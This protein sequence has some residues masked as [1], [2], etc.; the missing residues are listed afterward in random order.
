[1]DRNNFP[2]NDT[3]GCEFGHATDGRERVDAPE[4]TEYHLGFSTDPRL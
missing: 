1:M 2:A 4:S 3:H